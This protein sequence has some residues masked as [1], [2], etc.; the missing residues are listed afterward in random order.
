M[1]F[2]PTAAHALNDVPAYWHRCHGKALETDAHECVLGDTSGRATRTIALVGDSATG[3][4]MIPLDAIG[5]ARHWK[6]ITV[7]HTLCT[8]TAAMTVHPLVGPGPYTACHTWGE[9]AQRFLLALKPDVVISSDRP[10]VR[11]PTTP[12]GSTAASTA[13]GRG[14]A[15]YWR[16]L[17]AAHIAVV[18][19]RETPEPGRDEPQCLEAHSVASCS[20][21]RSVAIAKI[22]PVTVADAAVNGRATLIDLNR[23][24]C[25]AWC[26]PVVGNVEV[27]R[28]AHHMTQTFALTLAPYL[29]RALLKVPALANG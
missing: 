27:Y 20:T 5:K 26:S 9:N 4:W 23:L 11:T 6:I 19:I 12:G 25:S 2:V 15:V 14:M 21:P 7:L 16:Q 1:A 24:I 17:L 22:T 3:A 8:W 29:E 10:K 18:A 28:D 13:V